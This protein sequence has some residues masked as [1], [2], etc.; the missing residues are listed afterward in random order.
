MPLFFGILYMLSLAII[1][2]RVRRIPVVFLNYYGCTGFRTA[3]LKAV[4]ME[5]SRERIIWA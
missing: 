1:I 5:V 3:G 2:V 4:G